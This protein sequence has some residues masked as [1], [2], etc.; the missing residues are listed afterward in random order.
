MNF[1]G[2]ITHITIG[3]VMVGRY[4]YLITFKPYKEIHYS[5]YVKL[6][7]VRTILYEW[8]TWNSENEIVKYVNCEENHK[9]FGYSERNACDNKRWQHFP[10]IRVLHFSD[11]SA[12]FHWPPGCLTRCHSL[13]LSC[14]GHQKVGHM[15]SCD[16][17]C[18]TEGSASA[19]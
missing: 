7:K 11:I 10:L 6:N 1:I 14:V 16:I 4:M 13:L 2:Y 12:M 19:I 3:K 8:S 5:K 17:P 18:D 15:G 9:T